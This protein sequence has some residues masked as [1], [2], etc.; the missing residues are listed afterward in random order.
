MTHSSRTSSESQLDEEVDVG[1]WPSN[2]HGLCIFA[3]LKYKT[4]ILILKND[5]HLGDDFQNVISYYVHAS[6]AQKLQILKLM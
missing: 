1:G 5:W 6:G 2:L 4:N 3:A